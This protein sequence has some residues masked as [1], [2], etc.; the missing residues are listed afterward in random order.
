MLIA[1]RKLMSEVFEGQIARNE[2]TISFI[3]HFVGASV[4]LYLSSLGGKYF[5]GEKND[6]E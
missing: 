1:R 4:C 6:A 5:F 3:G 2:M